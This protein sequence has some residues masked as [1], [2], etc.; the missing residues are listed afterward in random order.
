MSDGFEWIVRRV[1]VENIAV[2]LKLLPKI[3]QFKAPFRLIENTEDN[4]M[5]AALSVCRKDLL[6]FR[7]IRTEDA[8]F[9][10]RGDIAIFLSVVRV[11]LLLQ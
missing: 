10:V 8:E 11:I 5:E 6:I 9:I 7:G 3:L 1:K 2:I 4:F